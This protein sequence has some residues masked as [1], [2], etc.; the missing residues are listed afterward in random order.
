MSIDTSAPA[1]HSSCQ[2]ILVYHLMV[3]LYW[4]V[5]HSAPMRYWWAV[6][7][8]QQNGDG[9]SMERDLL[10][11]LDCISSFAHTQL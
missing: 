2:L 6:R 11:M 10:C 8:I 3:L 4:V 5:E 9:I 1:F 7:T